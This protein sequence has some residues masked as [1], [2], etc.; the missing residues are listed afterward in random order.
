MQ[1]L[2]GQFGIKIRIIIIKNKNKNETEKGETLRILSFVSVLSKISRSA[3]SQR[4]CFINE[5]SLY[6]KFQNKKQKQMKTYHQYTIVTEQNNC[7]VVRL[8]WQSIDRPSCILLFLLL[9]LRL[10]VLSRRPRQ[11]CARQRETGTGGSLAVRPA[12]RFP[13]RPE[14]NSHL[15]RLSRQ[16]LSL[17]SLFN[18]INSL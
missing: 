4:K 11:P 9:L 14:K 8:V 6:V 17:S 13:R 16:S 10:L 7:R 18:L 2:L 3:L 5:A 15:R 12:L 1:T